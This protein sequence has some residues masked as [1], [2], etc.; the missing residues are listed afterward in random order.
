MVKFRKKLVVIEAWQW[1]G[2]A[3]GDARPDWVRVGEYQ[4]TPD[5]ELV[6]PTRVGVRYASPGDWIIRDSMGEVYPCKPHIFRATYEVVQ[7]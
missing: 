2:E 5:R 3:A 4:T 6:V 7:E 1:D